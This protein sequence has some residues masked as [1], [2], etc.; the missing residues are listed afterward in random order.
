MKDYIFRKIII[1]FL[2]FKIDFAEK[3][4]KDE[5]FWSPM[6]DA[7]PHNYPLVPERPNRVK[8]E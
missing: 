3:I 8:G 6:H 2:R 1:P 4:I 5:K 7:P